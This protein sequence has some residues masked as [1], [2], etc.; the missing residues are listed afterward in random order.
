[1]RLCVSGAGSQVSPD[2]AVLQ[3]GLSGVRGLELIPFAGV[4][5]AMVIRMQKRII[6]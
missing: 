1:M 6:A 4:C 2:A 5:V 3:I